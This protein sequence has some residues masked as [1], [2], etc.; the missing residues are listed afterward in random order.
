MAGRGARW[1]AVPVL[2]CLAGCGPKSAP[3]PIFVGQL[4]PLTGADRVVGEHARQGAELAVD[5]FQAAD[6]KVARRSVTLL[7]ADDR[8][9]A[10]EVSAQAVRLLTVNKTVALLSGFDATLTERL[11][12]ADQPYGAPV[13]VPGEL[14]GS[15][16]AEGVLV[17]G[18]RPGDRG[19]LL[20]RHASDKLKAVRAAVLTDSRNPVATDVASGFVKAWPR[21]GKFSLEERSYASATEAAELATWVG[22]ARPDIVLIAGSVRDF[23]KVRSQLDANGPKAVLY[24]GED[25]GPSS[26]TGQLE[27]GPKVYLATAYCQERLTEA[28]KDFARRYEE[29]FHDAPDLY[30]AQSHDACRLVLEALHRSQATTTTALREDLGRLESFDTVTGPVSWKNHQPH[31]ALFLVAIEDGRPTLIET[32]EPREE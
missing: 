25:A 19:Q 26:L 24:G 12:R 18:A 13:V 3:E 1:W 30:A 16:L 4:V 29:R 15:A 8:G 9:E 28:G 31:R 23:R 5:E 10:A 2:L 14:P 27:K 32:F 21:G 6:R 22:K 7:H 17:L 11:L 20:A